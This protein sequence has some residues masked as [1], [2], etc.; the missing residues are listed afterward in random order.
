MQ[1]T[2]CHERG[3]GLI[4]LACGICVSQPCP[5][6]VTKISCVDLMLQ[7]IT[8]KFSVANISSTLPFHVP[9]LLPLYSIDLQEES[10]I[11]TS[12]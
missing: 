5:Q 3:V 8:Q 9:K 10:M 12:T 2:T 7:D 1:T 11:G 6:L 4:Y